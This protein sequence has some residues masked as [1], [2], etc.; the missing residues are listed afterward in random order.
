MSILRRK[1]QKIVHP[2]LKLL[3]VTGRR[4][5]Y[6]ANRET[7]SCR[8]RNVAQAIKSET[9]R[10]GRRLFVLPK[11]P[12]L[13]IRGSRLHSDRYTCLKNM[14]P[15][16][17]DTW[18]LVLIRKRHLRSEVK[19]LWHVNRTQKIDKQLKSLLQ[20]KQ[21]ILNVFLNTWGVQMN[22]CLSCMEHFGVQTGF[23]VGG[24]IK[25]DV[26]GLK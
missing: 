25:F 10:A 26:V 24:S 14:K 12:E 17:G 5:S 22:I 21:K 7:S 3:Y 18:P 15:G 9:D 16:A 2:D 23:G 6:S 13:C 19:Y 20:K 8:R 4:A 1:N 11:P